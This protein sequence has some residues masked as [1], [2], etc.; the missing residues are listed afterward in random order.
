[1]S[2]VLDSANVVDYSS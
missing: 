1:M 2:S